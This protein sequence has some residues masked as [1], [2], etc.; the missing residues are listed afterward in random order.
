MLLIN[1]FGECGGVGGGVGSAVGRDMR[2]GVVGFGR[3]AT[4]VHD[5][6]L[7]SVVADEIGEAGEKTGEEA[8]EET[9]V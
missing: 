9:G 8:G 4:S 3:E 1:S 6:E 5:I 2:E 7:R